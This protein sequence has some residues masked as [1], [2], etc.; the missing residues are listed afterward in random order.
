MLHWTGL[1]ARGKL[2]ASHLNF[3]HGGTLANWRIVWDYDERHLKPNQVLMHDAIRTAGRRGIEY[4][5]LGASPAD[6][7]GL[8][9]YKE[10]WGGMKVEYDILTFRSPIRRLLGR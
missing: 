4:V 2:I 9:E 6:A 5:N 3:I 1:R 8:I 7:A 10:R